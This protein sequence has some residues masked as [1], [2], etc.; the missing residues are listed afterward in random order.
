MT[1]EE[2]KLEQALQT[3]LYFS[4][5]KKNAWTLYKKLWEE[6]KKENPLYDLPILQNR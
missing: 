1:L 4:N 5:E 6:K 2:S 3:F